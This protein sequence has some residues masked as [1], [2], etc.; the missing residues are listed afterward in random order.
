MTA[1]A[2]LRTKGYAVVTIKDRSGLD[3]VAEIFSNVLQGKPG[4]VG[5]K[6]IDYFFNSYHL[7]RDKSKNINELRMKAIKKLNRIPDLN[8]SICD[9]FYGDFKDIF[10]PDI[11]VQKGI[12]LVIQEP[13]DPDPSE[14]HRDFPSNSAYEIVLW[15]PLCDCSVN[16]TM[17]LVDQPNSIELAR[18]IR[19][20]EKIDWEKFTKKAK[21]IAKPC[22]VKYGQGLIFITTL[23]H[24]SEVNSSETTRISINLRV[25]GLFSPAGQKNPFDFWQIYKTGVLTNNAIEFEKL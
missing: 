18:E 19:Y 12:N 25:K 4:T 23:F 8:F 10:G 7:F 14:L 1:L 11:I 9:L 21:Q 6:S 3:K 13:G 22:P 20:S 2:N 5:Y 17:Y 15:L 16:K 24:G